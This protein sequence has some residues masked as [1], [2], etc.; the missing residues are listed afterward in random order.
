M[1][2]MSSCHGMNDDGELDSGIVNWLVGRL[3]G[4]ST[5]LPVRFSFMSNHPRDPPFLWEVKSE[6]K[7]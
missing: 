5:N 1:V 2:A 6:Q 3:V 7:R 4:H